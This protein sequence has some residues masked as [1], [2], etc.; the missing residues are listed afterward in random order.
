MDTAFEI[1]TEA[2][3]AI[4]RIP[5][6]EREEIG[7]LISPRYR[8]YRGNRVIEQFEDKHLNICQAS[9]RSWETERDAVLYDVDG[10]RLWLTENVEKY[11]LGKTLA[12]AKPE[13]GPGV[14]K[15]FLVAV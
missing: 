4:G 10:F 13:V 3:E 6:R 2:K 5:V 11:L 14:W 7:F 1:T 8:K 12:I 15:E 9:S